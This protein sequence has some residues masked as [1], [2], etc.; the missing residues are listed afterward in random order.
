M[1][2]AG[3]AWLDDV[4]AVVKINLSDEDAEIYVVETNL[5]QRGFSNLKISEQAFAVALRYN[6]L[7][8]E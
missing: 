8:D 4:P 7:F 2:A 1:Y 5:T 6:K 3:Q